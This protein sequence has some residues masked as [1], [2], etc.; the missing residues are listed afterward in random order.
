MNSQKTQNLL[1]ITKKNAILQ[2]KIEALK[3]GDPDAWLS[4]PN[5]QLARWAK[6]KQ[7]REWLKQALT[8]LEAAGLLEKKQDGAKRLLRLTASGRAAA[9]LIR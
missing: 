3:S 1:Q 8:S 7:G 5:D 6:T 4:V 9:E 2:L